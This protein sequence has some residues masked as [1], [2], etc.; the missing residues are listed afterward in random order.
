MR[1]AWVG[2]QFEVFAVARRDADQERSVVRIELVADLAH[3]ESTEL[4]GGSLLQVAAAHRR[5]PPGTGKTFT[6]MYLAR[7][8]TDRT[9]L[10]VTGRQQGLIA[11]VCAMA[12]LL[13]PATVIL[14]D[15]DLIAED[16]ARSDQNACSPLLFDLLNE[17]D[18][19][20]PDADVLFIL[21]TNRPG[22]LEP[23]LAARP[24]RVDLA[25]EV[26][27]PDAECRRR[28][29]TSYSKGLSLD[30]SGLDSWVCAP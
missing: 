17:M 9:V 8:M 11:S 20:R 7:Q 28:L 13:E 6:A 18:G 5:G 19:L 16:R 29:I 21:T 2:N 15:V 25:V 24:G 12:R 4:T 14:E 10:L 3:R 26:P 23:A 30:L 1:A 27:L 22:A